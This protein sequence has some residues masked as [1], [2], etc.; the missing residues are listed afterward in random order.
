MPS[1]R[2]DQCQKQQPESGQASGLSERQHRNDT[3][4]KQ[5]NDGVAIRLK[6]GFQQQS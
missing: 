5:S 2:R 3:R 4:S 6:I 1:Y